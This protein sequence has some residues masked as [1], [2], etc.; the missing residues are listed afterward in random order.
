MGKMSAHR[1]SPGGTSVRLGAGVRA[2]KSQSEA[3]F[4]CLSCNLCQTCDFCSNFVSPLLQ[5]AAHVGRM[6]P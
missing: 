4:I 3:L 1:S 5:P 2:G 6:A